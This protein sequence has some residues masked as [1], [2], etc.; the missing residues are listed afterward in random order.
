MDGFGSGVRFTLAAEPV[1]AGFAGLGG[2]SS[3]KDS[4]SSAASDESFL[5]E[6]MDGFD[7]GVRFTL[8]AEPVAAGFAGLGGGSS[9]KDSIS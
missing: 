7:S 5:G 6:N 4:I 8:A 9:H 1:A 2:G 3:H